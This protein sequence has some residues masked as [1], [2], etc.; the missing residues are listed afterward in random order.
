M[1]KVSLFFYAPSARM[2]LAGTR[3]VME[4]WAAFISEFWVSHILQ[5]KLVSKSGRA[6]G[7]PWCSWVK[8]EWVGAVSLSPSFNSKVSITFEVKALIE[9]NWGSSW[10]WEVISLL[11][12]TLHPT[13]S[14]LLRLSGMDLHI[15]LR[16]RE[17]FPKVSVV[18]V[19]FFFFSVLWL[20]KK[21]KKMTIWAVL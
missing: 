17:S 8:N 13:D 20:R 19:F 1:K 11:W 15:W 18:V 4:E 3:R 14:S 6:P 9:K 7:G 16:N 5:S 2:N 21:K 10:E 12:Q